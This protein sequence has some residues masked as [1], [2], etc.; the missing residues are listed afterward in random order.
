MT[1]DRA[2]WSDWQRAEAAEQAYMASMGNHRGAAAAQEFGMTVAEVGGGVVWATRA[3]PTG[4]FF[5]RA[6]GQ[7]VRQPITEAVVDE[8]IAVAT[9]AGAPVRSGC[10]VGRGHAAGGP[11]GKEPSAA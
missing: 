4:G 2:G 11:E 7:G 1:D 5:C 8:V 3:D 9:E 6:V 10:Y